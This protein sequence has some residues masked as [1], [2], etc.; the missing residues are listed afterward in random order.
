LTRPQRVA[1]PPPVL[2]EAQRRVVEHSAGPLLVLAGPGTGKTTTLVETVVARVAGG[3]PVDDI[4]MLTFS[5]KAAGELRDRVT[6]RLARTVREPIART[7]HS[8]AFGLLRIAAVRSAERG[9]TIK[10]TPRLLGG[11][12][13]DVVVRE[14]LAGGGA[15]DWPAALHPAL[16]TSG[17]A[18]ELRELIMRAKE[19]GYD[20]PA[21]RELGSARG[22]ADWVAAGEFLD[23]YE[24]VNA[25]DPAKGFDQA[26]LIRAA[27]NA[28]EGDPELLAAERAR[29]RR[30]YVDEYQDTDPAQ[31][32]LLQLLAFGADEVILVGDPDQSIYAFRGADEAAITRVDEHF[33]RGAAVPVVAL[34]TC[35][36]S[37]AALL[38]A[39]RRVAAK[40]P[41][42]GEQRALAPTEGAPPGRAEVRVF[43]GASE[44]AAYIANELRR[45]GLG[46]GDGEA[47]PWSRMAVLVRST[48]AIGTLRRALVTAGV[49]IAVR[50]EELPLAEQ[51][52]VAML[53]DVLAYATGRALTDELAEALLTG[54]IGGGDS[55]FL[56]RLAR[57]VRQV[58]GL[59]PTARV[60][61]V[62]V[63]TDVLGA[64]LLPERV[65]RP[66]VTVARTLAAARAAAVDGGN[67][68]TVLWA[69]WAASGLGPMWE[70]AALRADAA[71]A[72]ANRD[73]DAVLQLFAEAAA[74]VDRLPHESPAGF[75]QHLRAQQIPGGPL[76]RGGGVGEGV[77]IL[78]AHSSK[79]LEWDFVV[80]AGVQEGSWPD[81]RRRGTLLGTEQLVDAAEGVADPDPAAS[82]KQLAEERRLFYV[83]A[84]R[85]RTRLLATAVSGEE[86]QPSRFLDELLPAEQERPLTRLPRAA[87]RSGVVAHL[88]GVVCDPAESPETRGEAAGLLAELAA[89]GV[90]GADPG[91][92][93]GLL[94]L[95]TEEPVRVGEETV[96]VGPSRI[97]SF[98]DCE[99]KALMELL[100]VRDGD[101]KAAEL[102][103]L[104]HSI[105]Q[106]ADDR[107]I[108]ELRAELDAGIEGLDFGAAWMKANERER[109]HAMLD[110]FVEWLE[111]SR[112]EFE[113]VG[114]ELAFE[115]EVGGALLTGRV[116][117][118]EKD[119]DGRL[120]VV[121]LKTGKTKPGAA[122]IPTMPQLG[123]Y[124]LAIEHGAFEEHGTVAGGAMLVQVG[125]ATS[126][127]A[128]EQRQPALSE[129]ED[130]DWARAQVEHVV[131][132][133]RGSTFT[134]RHS[135]R[136][137]V[138]DV[139]TTCPLQDEGGQ[140]TS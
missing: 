13:Q 90:P 83:A 40:L 29:R 119:A 96:R 104:I 82:A 53:L 101:F 93:W 37:G 123:A 11:A 62:P 80:V 68:E 107:P 98:I 41:G 87:H 84:T 58:E 138:C 91:E 89:A 43:R 28:L 59:E 38:E 125:A 140:V 70:R 19:R 109:A 3:V 108:E 97:E 22:R 36:R 130:P 54:P 131:R 111:K 102:G 120:V 50:R 63:V 23:E 139:R 52:V 75:E 21:L 110:V 10:T 42:R 32:Q 55:L 25:L 122:K 115:V 1:P 7:L 46:T 61:F 136:C 39:T 57:A 65:R 8:Y 113:Q 73:L 26:A 94:S 69:A 14:L 51:P 117:R 6:A 60:S 128:A 27:I 71:G 64:D 132:V 15:V 133:V 79:G 99:L 137:R 31:V 124:Q 129:A 72:A 105:A 114:N 45:A 20:G 30:I 18:S 81:L 17:F 134:A 88:R 33:G 48:G 127:K 85:A 118:L 126:A 44:E 112:G 34:R 86:E 67:A 78:T 135:D 116:D 5:R 103:T 47:L 2:D 4:L 35:R 56:R 95:S 49:P 74:F 92:W 66:V 9:E 106:T 76:S 77:E 24:E 16:G 121:D 12:E 100:G